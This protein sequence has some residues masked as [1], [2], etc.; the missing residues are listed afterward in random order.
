[1]G[2]YPGSGWKEEGHWPGSWARGY[3]PGA[4]LEACHAHSQVLGPSGWVQHWPALW[5]ALLDPGGPACWRLQLR[6]EAAVGR[7]GRGEVW[8]GVRG[9]PHLFY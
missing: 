9:R 2:G 4:H 6:E 5:L 7:G 3:L 1:M 8:G